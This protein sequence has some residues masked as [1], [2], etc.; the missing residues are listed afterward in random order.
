M[1]LPKN[2]P[3]QLLIDRLYKQTIE[4]NLSSREYKAII[5]L[6]TDLEQQL[7][8]YIIKGEYRSVA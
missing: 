5:N 1:L 6:I 8:F 3:V 2:H 7:P 4:S